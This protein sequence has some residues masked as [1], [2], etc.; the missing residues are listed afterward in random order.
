MH[1]SNTRQLPSTGR[2]VIPCYSAANKTNP[3][4]LAENHNFCRVHEQNADL[5]LLTGCS[6]LGSFFSGLEERTATMVFGLVLALGDDGLA[7]WGR[8]ASPLGRSS[9]FAGGSSIL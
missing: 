1:L 2:S 7:S 4:I 3:Q 6:V 5:A 8:S 9:G